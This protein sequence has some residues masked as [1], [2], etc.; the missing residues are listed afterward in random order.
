MPNES[1]ETSA[2]ARDDLFHAG[3]EGK[4]LEAKLIRPPGEE[5]S[6]V[7]VICDR[8]RCTK[9]DR[10]V[11]VPMSKFLPSLPVTGGQRR[12]FAG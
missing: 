4:T 11:S 12:V 2:I 3:P 8:C 1:D 5:P 7:T 10:P 6:A 9:M